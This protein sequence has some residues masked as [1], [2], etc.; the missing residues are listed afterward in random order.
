M[1][2]ITAHLMFT[3]PTVEKR[4]RFLPLSNKMV[5]AE[6]VLDSFNSFPPLWRT[7][8]ESLS[9]K[10]FGG[11]FSKKVLGNYGIIQSTIAFL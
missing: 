8:T 1:H 2:K 6:E 7:F 5:F 11:C 4:D 9:N 10:R 3:V